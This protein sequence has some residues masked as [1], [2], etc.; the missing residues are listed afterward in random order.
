MSA[1]TVN[2]TRQNCDKAIEKLGF[3]YAT[4]ISA[5]TT[6]IRQQNLSM[7]IEI[8]FIPT[9]PYCTIYNLLYKEFSTVS[10]YR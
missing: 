4:S 5:A 6:N 8:I 2:Y 3:E 9:I 7:I 1:P 10:S